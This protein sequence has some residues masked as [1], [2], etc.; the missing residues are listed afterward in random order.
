MELSLTV[1]PSIVTS[2]KN[3]AI[4]PPRLPNSKVELPLIVLLVNESRPSALLKSSPPPEA[5]SSVVRPPVIVSPLSVRSAGVVLEKFKT[6]ELSSSR[7]SAAPAMPPKLA[8]T[9]VM[10]EAS[11]TSSPFAS[12]VIVTSTAFEASIVSESVIS[13]SPLVR[14][15]R[16]SAPPVKTFES[17]VTVSAPSVL[18]LATMASRK[19]MPSAPGELIKAATDEVS[20]STR[21]SELLTVSVARSRRSSR[22]SKRCDLLWLLR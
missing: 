21:S 15:I 16:L 9:L 6:R 12:P 3:A 7:S 2:A 19:E 1:L 20:P 5:L 4:P 14:R 18:L 22:A 13:N 11:V 17:K 8:P 10:K